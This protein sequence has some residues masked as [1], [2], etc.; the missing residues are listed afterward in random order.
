MFPWKNF[1]Y[2]FGR[3]SCWHFFIS[4]IT[5]RLIKVVMYIVSLHYVKTLK[6]AGIAVKQ[7]D[8]IDK[9]LSNTE[10]MTKYFTVFDMTLTLLALVIVIVGFYYSVVFSMKRTLFYPYNFI[11]LTIPFDK[12]I[13]WRHLTFIMIGVVLADYLLPLIID[14]I[15]KHL[16]IGLIKNEFVSTFLKGCIY[17]TSN[18]ISI[19]FVLQLYLDKNAN[20]E[21]LP[22][23]KNEDG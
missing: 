1:K 13:P 3:F 19:Y 4:Y 9:L 22:N 11:K 15:N 17:I 10:Y 20:I 12:K 6:N 8:N 14:A 16:F 18:L 23:T 2:I 5:T 21:C 7:A